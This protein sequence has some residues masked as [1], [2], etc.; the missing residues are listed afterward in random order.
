MIA[1]L[2]AAAAFESRRR[3]SAPGELPFPEVAILPLRLRADLG[4]TLV[5]DRV[6]Q[7]ADQSGTSHHGVQA[8]S[9]N[10]PTVVEAAGKAALRFVEL[11]DFLTIPHHADLQMVSGWHLWIAMA[12]DSTVLNSPLIAKHA[13]GNIEWHLALNQPT[14]QATRL[15]IRNSANN[16]TGQIIGARANTGGVRVIRASL[17]GTAGEL[18]VDGEDADTATFA[19]FRQ[20]TT[21]VQ[22]P[23]YTGATS[24]IPACD[25][26][27]IVIAV[28]STEEAA[29]INAYMTSRYGVE[30]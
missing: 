9:G 8:T 7:W 29:A 5:D 19:S 3:A 20:A 22:I 17:I 10:R 13:T 24:S 15:A 16:A 12:S 14:G 27:E 2:E 6:S 30:L 21:D 26:F 18:K 28:P 11:Q 4:V 25:I 23:G 1:Y